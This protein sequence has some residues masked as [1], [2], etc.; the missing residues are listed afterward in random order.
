MKSCSKCNILKS[1]SEYYVRRNRSSGY[2]SEC[3]VCTKSAV[4]RW[5]KK[6][7]EKVY[8]KKRAWKVRNISDVRKASDVYRESNRDKY[9][10]A[11][12]NH[13]YRN[14]DKYLE[15]WARRKAAKLKAIP[16]W[17]N[18]EKIKE[19]YRERPKGYHVDH[20]IPLQGKNVCGLHVEY[21][22]QYLPAKENLSKGNRIATKVG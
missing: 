3:K 14:K 13:Y 18:L 2:Y 10:K 22:L 16:S 15:A 9:R 11:C 17:A 20:I 7:P 5:N 19:I 8:A 4:E 21:N 6:N 1:L 12:L